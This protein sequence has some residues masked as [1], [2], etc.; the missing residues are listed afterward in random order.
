MCP[1]LNFDK[2]PPVQ[3]S[4]CPPFQRLPLRLRIY[5]SQ[6]GILKMVGVKLV[7][8]GNSETYRQMGSIGQ[9]N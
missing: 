7:D 8:Y 1:I 3:K 5:A 4:G 2:Y 6:S 9:R